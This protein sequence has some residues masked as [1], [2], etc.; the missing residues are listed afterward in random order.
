MSISEKDVIL[1]IKDKENNRTIFRPYTTISQVKGGVA[2]VNGVTPDNLGNVTISTGGDYDEEIA[3]LQERTRLIVSSAYNTLT[4]DGAITSTGNI[5]ANQFNG[6]LNGTAN[7]AVV[8]TQDSQGN[9]LI[10]DYVRFINDIAPV[11]GKITLNIPSTDNFVPK[12]DVA[13]AANKIPRYSS[14]GHLV[15]PSGVEIW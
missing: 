7:A 14:E 3:D 6:I 4:V 11:N 12:S 1:Y 10:N 2:S 9:L 15:L 8:A 13:N 5:T